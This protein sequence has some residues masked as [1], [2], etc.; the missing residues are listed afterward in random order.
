MEFQFQA[1][2]EACTVSDTSPSAPIVHAVTTIRLLANVSLSSLSL[3][4]YPTWQVEKKPNHMT[5][6]FGAIA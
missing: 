5:V 1:I 4:L 6:I 2:M 3:S